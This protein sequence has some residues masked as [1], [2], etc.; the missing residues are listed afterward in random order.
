MNDLDDSALEV[1]QN[2]IIAL[3]ENQENPVIVAT[4]P[5]DV[6]FRK[7]TIMERFEVGLPNIDIR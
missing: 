7:L 1:E 6:T 2:S 5:R 4:C 3:C